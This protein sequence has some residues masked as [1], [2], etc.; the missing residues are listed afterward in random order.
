M[1]IEPAG[2]RCAA[3]T[4][5]V[6][7]RLIV[8]CLFSF[9]G[10]AAAGASARAADLERQFLKHAPQVIKYL[11][12]K[13]CKNVGVLKFIVKKDADE[14][15]GPGFSD[16]A[17]TLNLEAAQR[18]EMALVLANSAR[19]PIGIVHNASRVAATTPGAN[20]LTPEGR[21]PLFVPR[22]PLAWGG[23]SVAVDTFI[24]GCIQ[25]DRDFKQMTV[26]LAAFDAG[27]KL[28]KVVDFPA[29]ME[30]ENVA[31]V[32]ESFVY[33]GAFDKR[34]LELVALNDAAKIRQ[35]SPEHPHPLKTQD[36]PVELQI[37]YGGRPV[38]VQVRDGRALIPEPA[39][40]Q[41][42]A[43]V[44]ARKDPADPSRYACV[45]KVNGENTA[46]R[47]RLRDLLCHKWV[48]EPG[49][50]SIVIRGYQLAGN[51]AEAFHVLSPQQSK[52][53]EIDYGD[54]VGL[55]TLEVFRERPKGTEPP[56]APAADDNYEDLAALLRSDFP[57]APAENIDALQ[58]QLRDS[59][60]SVSRGIIVSGNE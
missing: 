41:D 24:V 55:I 38:A 15:Q 45:L 28:E 52:A 1:N 22:Y 25:V 58:A 43:F 17:G 14:G 56:P 18:L 8:A 19:P 35:G 5:A 53:R 12:D 36:A 30:A 59:A 20:H 21:K 37:R 27:C 6:G 40:G 60:I 54:D 31:E 34:K 49:D 46:E 3:N 51:K 44:L 42:V 26:R 10:L 33:R 11:E 57:A 29:A 50:P 9:F 47:E 48:L 32:G 16:R 39:A 23:A 2:I 13:G 7:A 4:R